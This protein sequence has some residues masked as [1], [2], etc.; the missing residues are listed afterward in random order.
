MDTVTDSRL[1]SWLVL[2]GSNSFKAL[3]LTNVEVTRKKISKRN[4]MSVIDDMLKFGF[5]LLFL[6]IAMLF[7]VLSFVL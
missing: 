6:L 7:P 1:E 2:L 3:G 5:I 4:T